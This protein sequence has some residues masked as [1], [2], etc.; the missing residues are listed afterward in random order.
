MTIQEVEHE[1]KTRFPEF[2]EFKI[3]DDFKMTCNQVS[4][5]NGLATATLKQPFGPQLTLRDSNVKFDIVLSIE[6]TNR[7]EAKYDIAHVFWSRREN[8]IYFFES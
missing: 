5:F 7:S 8:D 4:L 2:N 1:I 3:H 6:F